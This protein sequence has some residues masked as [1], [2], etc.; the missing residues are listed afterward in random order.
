MVT[1]HHKQMRNMILPPKILLWPPVRILPL[2]EICSK[3]EAVQHRPEYPTER[4][5]HRFAC[6]CQGKLFQ[7]AA[8]GWV[9][10]N[11][12]LNE[13]WETGAELCVQSSL[14]HSHR[15]T[16]W[17]PAAF[18]TLQSYSSLCCPLGVTVEAPVLCGEVPL[19]IQGPPETGRNPL[20][21]SFS[22]FVV[23][24]NTNSANRAGELDS[25]YSET[26]FVSP[27]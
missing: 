2:P 12:P 7:S 1:F 10:H 20:T 22:Y 14:C 11:T 3:T 5:W 24:S 15:R 9:L 16:A 4:Q 17:Q 21:C 27:L 13:L 8:L 23:P 19:S 25:V 6:S 18:Q 26:A